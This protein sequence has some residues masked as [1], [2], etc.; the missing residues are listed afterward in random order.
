MSEQ[1]DVT[2][3]PDGGTNN[4]DE[5]TEHILAHVDTI[6]RLVP[7]TEYPDKFATVELF[8]DGEWREHQTDCD[9]NVADEIHTDIAQAIEEGLHAFAVSVGAPRLREY[10]Q[11]KPTCETEKRPIW[12]C[13]KCGLP[14]CWDYC[15]A[16]KKL[17]Y[18]VVAPWRCTCGL[19]A[20]LTGGHD[21]DD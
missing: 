9:R 6:V 20:L 11:H 13:L 8:I 16:C 21:D 3:S 17:G 7:D 18:E 15:Q 2:P 4:S 10:V 19:D 12:N 1:R 5:W 14:T